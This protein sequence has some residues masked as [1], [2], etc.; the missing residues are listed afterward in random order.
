MCICFFLPLEWCSKGRWSRAPASWRKPSLPPPEFQL[1]A[2]KCGSDEARE[3]VE[4][5]VLKLMNGEK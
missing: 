3:V 2:K 4:K 5:G 1:P